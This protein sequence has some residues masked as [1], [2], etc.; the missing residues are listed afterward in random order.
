M[1]RKPIRSNLAQKDHDDEADYGPL[2]GQLTW[3]RRSRNA[4]GSIRPS[5]QEEMF[6]TSLRGVNDNHD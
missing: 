4:D 3:G 2:T 1:T 5:E 6:W